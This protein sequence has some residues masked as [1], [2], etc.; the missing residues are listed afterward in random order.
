MAFNMYEGYFKNKPYL[1][2]AVE[3]MHTAIRNSKEIDQA[4]E[5]RQL[6]TM[7]DTDNER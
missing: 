6:Q 3:D 4:H 5:E 2:E 7:W 1:R